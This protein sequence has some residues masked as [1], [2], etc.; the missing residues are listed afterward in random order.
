MKRRMLSMML[1]I[2]LV[3]LGGCKTTDETP[4]T[5]PTIENPSETPQE[6][7]PE[8]NNQE[9]VTTNPEGNSSENKEPTNANLFEYQYYD[10]EGNLQS[11]F[12]KLIIPEAVEAGEVTE[13]VKYVFEN[14]VRLIVPEGKTQVNLIPSVNRLLKLEEVVYSSTLVEAHKSTGDRDNVC[15]ISS[16]SLKKFTVLAAETE[17]YTF[18]GCS[19]LESLIFE[20]AK[21]NNGYL[22]GFTIDRCP[23]LKEVIFLEDFTTIDEY[24]IR[25]VADDCIFY[26]P[27]GGN[28]EQYMKDQGFTYQINK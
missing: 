15:M 21:M 8:T 28:L 16:A 10:T 12:G 27:A 5:T 2:S 4:V 19:A 11:Y 20:S 14:A 3:M 17:K 1:V 7:F 9:E 26:I 13:E 6:N 18:H 23:N 24:A 22:A 25:G